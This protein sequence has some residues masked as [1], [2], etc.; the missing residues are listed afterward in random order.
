MALVC[1]ALAGV[2]G[3]KVTYWRSAAFA[4][5]PRISTAARLESKKSGNNSDRKNV[6]FAQRPSPPSTIS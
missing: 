4:F 1:E 3:A 5:V 6:T 2:S